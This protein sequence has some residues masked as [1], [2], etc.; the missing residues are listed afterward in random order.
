MAKFTVNELTVADLQ[1]L[2]ISVVV[3]LS[4]SNVNWSDT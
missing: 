2:E 1:I 4:H 3:D